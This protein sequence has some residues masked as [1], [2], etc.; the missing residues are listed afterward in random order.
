MRELTSED[1]V[2]YWDYMAEH[3]DV[4]VLQKNSDVRKILRNAGGSSILGSEIKLVA[5]SLISWV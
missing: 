1:V 2:A 3:Y 5:C 4:K